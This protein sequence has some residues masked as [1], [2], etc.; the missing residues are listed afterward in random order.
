M[1]SRLYP[2]AVR[3]DGDDHLAVAHAGRPTD[4]R[5]TPTHGR[6]SGPREIA[7]F[8]G[9]YLTYFGVRAVAQGSAP[10]GVANAAKVVR[11]ERLLGMQWE[12]SL[13]SM[14][15]DDRALVR[16]ANWVYV[17]GTGRC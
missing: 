7:L 10:R 17:F 8:V 2:D 6:W 4:S 16:L 3:R 12:R 15:V 13:Q 14:M 5:A 11:V 1:L 9:G